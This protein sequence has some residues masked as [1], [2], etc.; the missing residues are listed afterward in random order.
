MLRASDGQ[1]D[2]KLIM[3]AI[4]FSNQL[5]SGDTANLVG[6]T[7]TGETS[8][9][10]AIIENVFKFQIGENQVTEFILNEDTITGTF[11]T[12][13]V[14]QG[15]ATDDDD[16]F[17]KVTITGIPN[18]I[19][20]TN[21]GSLY[22]SA[23]TVSIVGGGTGAI[24]NVNDIGRG[25]LTNFY[26]DNGGSGYVIGDDVI[27]NNTNTGGGA[28]QAKV[29]I[30]NGGIENE[31]DSGDRI[32]LED[33]TTSGDVYTGN[34]IVQESGSGDITDIRIINAGSNYLSLPIVTVDDTNG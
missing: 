22:S 6:R 18:S 21:S 33:E 2:S 28:A 30:V 8:G 24:I 32:V 29:S 1:W 12:S 31:D 9:A 15:T 20:I 26:V 17:I 7:I 11:Q 14:L 3:R 10:T 23:E 19:T 4:Q 34:V 5:S 16:L 27:F 25:S 13:E